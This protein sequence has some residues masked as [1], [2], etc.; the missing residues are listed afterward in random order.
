LRFVPEPARTRKKTQALLSP[1]VRG[2]SV[3]AKTGPVN[4]ARSPQKTT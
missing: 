2:V 1:P 3:A 4:P